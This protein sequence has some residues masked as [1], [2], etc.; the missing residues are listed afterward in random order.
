MNLDHD[1]VQVSKL[2]EDQKKSCSP[3]MEHFFPRIQME[4]C[5]Q[6]Q[7]TVKILGGDADVD[8][9]QIIGGIQSNYWGIQ[10]NYW[11][12][13]PPSPPNFGTLGLGKFY[14]SAAGKTSI[15]F[16]TEQGYSFAETFISKIF[17]VYFSKKIFFHFSAAVKKWLYKIKFKKKNYFCNSCLSSHAGNTLLVSIKS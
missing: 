13:I 17:F 9:T 7:T 12:Y 3:K 2:R 11:G 4:T 1:F 6:M 14:S 5:A 16:T 15:R 10:S 8:H